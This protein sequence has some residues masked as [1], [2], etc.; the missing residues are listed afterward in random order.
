MIEANPTTQIQSPNG[1]DIPPEIKR[2][3]IAQDLQLWRNTRYQSQ[4]RYRVQ[5]A[6]GGTTD[7]LKT[8]EDELLKDEQA[9]DFLESELK[10][11]AADLDRAAILNG[12]IVKALSDAA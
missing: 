3:I 4:L 1:A 8:I 5:K 6:I 2:Q 12:A 10:A 7:Q 11:L 9:I